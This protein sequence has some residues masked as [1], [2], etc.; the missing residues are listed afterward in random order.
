[1]LLPQELLRKYDIQFVH[2]Q[3][4]NEVLKPGL[5]GLLR[6]LLMEHFIFV[7]LSILCQFT[8]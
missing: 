7:A 5:E 8:R 3:V 4:R 6:L 1:M 2:L